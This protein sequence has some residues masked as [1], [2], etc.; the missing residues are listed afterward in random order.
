MTVDWFTLCTFIS[1]KALCLNLVLLL[2]LS[3]I[4]A[5]LLLSSVVTVLPL[6]S[7]LCD[8]GQTVSSSAHP[9][10]EGPGEGVHH[11]AGSGGRA[12]PKHPLLTWATTRSFKPATWHWL[13]L[14]LQYL[15]SL[16]HSQREL[17]SIQEDFCTHFKL[18]G[19]FKLLNSV[20]GRTWVEM[21][22]FFYHS[23]KFNFVNTS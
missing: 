7:L 12:P 13:H 5:L 1:L 4:S 10:G 8:P 3:C 22:L 9:G 11:S 20:W 16:L 15:D 19:V 14:T 2:S 23:S 18:G 6:P 17:N 21:S